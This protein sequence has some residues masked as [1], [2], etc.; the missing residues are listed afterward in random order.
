MVFF[1][2]IGGVTPMYSNLEVYFWVFCSSFPGGV[3]FLR[4]LFFLN[5][6]FLDPFQRKNHKNKAFLALFFGG[7]YFSGG[8]LFLEGGL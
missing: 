2:I 5:F 4:G 7:S 3:L 1:P 8:V 6:S